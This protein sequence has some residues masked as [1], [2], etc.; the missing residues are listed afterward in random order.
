MPPP[1]WL[2]EACPRL[3]TLL[4]TL[5]GALV[6]ATGFAY[7]MWDGSGVLAEDFR[8]SK[9]QL[10]EG[11]PRL[12]VVWGMLGVCF[13][14]IGLGLWL[15]EHQTN[16]Q[17]RRPPLCGSAVKH[18]RVVTRTVVTAVCLIGFWSAVRALWRCLTS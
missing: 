8:L 12:K 6:A 7:A 4:V 15:F 13:V 1:S 10:T 17:L 18:R 2:V 9:G 5:Y 16:R 14:L 3:P 11:Q